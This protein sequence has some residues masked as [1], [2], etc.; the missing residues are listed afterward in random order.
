MSFA[1]VI[2]IHKYRLSKAGFQKDD[3]FQEYKF[4]RTNWIP[5]AAF[6]TSQYQFIS[7]TNLYPC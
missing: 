5:K 3:A 4:A 1:S 6:L 7:L 2:N